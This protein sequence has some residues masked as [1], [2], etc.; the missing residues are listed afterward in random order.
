MAAS[1]EHF[2]KNIQSFRPDLQ[3]FWVLTLSISG[4]A[5]FEKEG[6]SFGHWVNSSCCR[7][8]RE[9]YRLPTIALFH[10]KLATRGRNGEE[11]QYSENFYTF[12]HGIHLIMK[13]IRIKSF[14][15]SF[16]EQFPIAWC[17]FHWGEWYLRK[18]S[19][20]IVEQKFN[21]KFVKSSIL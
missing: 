2:S 9:T 16:N 1:N 13:N 15:D 11:W 5:C 12:F 19:R 8:S 3:C 20:N 4:V 17:Q 14:I 21:W 6:S 10:A 7:V 18:T